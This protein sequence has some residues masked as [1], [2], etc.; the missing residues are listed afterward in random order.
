MRLNAITNSPSEPYTK[1]ENGEYIANIGNFHLSGAYG[2]Y[3]VHRMCN[4][5]GGISTPFISYHTTKRDLYD[6]L[7]AYIN[8]IVFASKSINEL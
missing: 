5:S 1:N 4:K 8:G 7:N 6:R 2:G 3:C